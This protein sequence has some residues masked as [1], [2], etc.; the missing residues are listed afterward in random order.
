[1]ERIP[2][3]IHAPTRGATA[4]SPIVRI[5]MNMFQSTRPR[6]ARPLFLIIDRRYREVSIHAPTRGA[7]RHRRRGY[8]RQRV[9]IH[10]PTRGATK[11]CA[12]VCGAPL[13]SI[14]APTR[15]ATAC[16]VQDEAV[17][18]RFQSTRPRGARHEYRNEVRAPCCCFN[19]RAHAGRDITHR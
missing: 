4:K 5:R 10:A 17:C 8:G 11:E 18:E 3:S 14:H 9:S 7:T 1:M 15:G 13:V 2:V 12:G 6:G 16:R 19:P